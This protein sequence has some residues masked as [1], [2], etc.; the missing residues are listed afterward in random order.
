MNGQRL[1]KSMIQ[2]YRSLS[3]LRWNERETY[4]QLRPL[5][6][7]HIQR[8]PDETVVRELGTISANRSN[9]GI[10]GRPTAVMARRNFADEA[11]IILKRVY[12]YGLVIWVL[13]FFMFLG[14]RP[15]HTASAHAP[16]R[17]GRPRPRT[18]RPPMWICDGHHSS[19]FS[20]GISR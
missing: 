9:H 2:R 4:F 6:G 13:G 14:D 5:I 18:R 1:I 7:L 3:T 19:P 20:T 10:F 12:P 11:V 15:V 16:V 8:K 17:T